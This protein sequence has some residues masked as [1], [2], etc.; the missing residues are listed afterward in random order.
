MGVAFIVKRTSVV[1]SI[2]FETQVATDINDGW[3][4]LYNNIFYTAVG[5]QLKAGYAYGGSAGAP[6]SQYKYNAWFLFTNVQIPQGSDMLVCN[7]KLIHGG[8]TNRANSPLSV[9]I[10]DE[11]NPSTVTSV[12]D[13]IS[14]PTI[15]GSSWTWTGAYGSYVSMIQDNNMAS[16]LETIVQDP[17][18]VIG[19]NILMMLKDEYVYS[20][21]LYEATSRSYFDKHAVE[22][23]YPDGLQATLQFQYAL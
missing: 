5:A 13:Y 15:F 10:V 16:A 23:G 2:L 3:V 6:S 1:P 4:D 9:Y 22:S 14:R 20:G 21:G 17:S 19:N 18:W 11:L 7:L 12:S 8:S